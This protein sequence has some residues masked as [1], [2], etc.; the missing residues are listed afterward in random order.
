MSDDIIDLSFFTTI[1]DH[2][3]DIVWKLDLKT[4]KFLYISPSVLKVRGYTPEE[5]MQL[6]LAESLPGPEYQQIKAAMADYAFMAKSGVKFPMHYKAELRHNKKGGGY[7][8]LEVKTTAILDENNIPRF[9]LGVSRDITEQK[10]RK[11]E[12]EESL[13][14]EKFFADIIRQSSQP[15]ALGRLDGGIVLLN[16]AAFDLFGYNEDEISHK[17]WITDLTPVKWLEKEKEI[18]T[19]CIHNNQSINYKKEFFHKTGRP[20]PVNMRVYPQVGHNTDNAHFI[21]F[22]N[23][24]SEV[25][26]TRYLLQESNERFN[27][28]L[29]GA[30]DGLWDWNM[31]T[32]YLFMS[33]RYL[34]IIGYGSD[35]LLPVIDSFWKLIHPDDIEK[36]YRVQDILYNDNNH[37]AEIQFRMRHKDGHYVHILSRAHLLRNENGMP[38]RLVGTHMDMSELLKVK[39]SLQ[40]SEEKYRML[41]SHSNIGICTTSID[42]QILEANQ[43]MYELLGIAVP[44]E[45]QYTDIRPFYL[46]ARD[47]EYFLQL[48]DLEG[49]V[50]N[51]QFQI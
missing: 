3:D 8:W 12:L 4:Q 5:A 27:L 6:T 48:L 17:N 9:A 38:V 24:L 37:N 40:E 29:K 49:Q 25:E 36:V 46:H 18:L 22:I 7:V 44:P 42:G 20:I 51:L 21:A 1:T 28:A 15:M 45:G 30:N 14:R 26:T 10:Q 35:E 31:E 39:T 47:R 23:D 2:I 41:F 33:P 34:D 11:A 13:E 32:N 19:E 50:K 43:S 16:Q